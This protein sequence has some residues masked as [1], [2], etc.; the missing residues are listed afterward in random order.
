[1]FPRG[2]LR[3]DLNWALGFRAKDIA[4]RKNDFRLKELLSSKKFLGGFGKG[5]AENL[6][7]VRILLSLLQNISPIKGS[8][9]INL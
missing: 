4:L 1:M 3:K 8:S 2:M 7:K 9:F 5:L 6:P